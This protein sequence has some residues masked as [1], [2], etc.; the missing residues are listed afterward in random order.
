MSHMIRED[1]QEAILDIMNKT[2]ESDKVSPDSH[3]FKE[4]DFAET[5][6]VSRSTIREAISSLEIRGYLKRVHGRGIKAIDSSIEAVSNSLNDLFI[7]SGVDYDDVLQFRN[8]IEI[9][10]AGIAA[11]NHKK[12]HL[13][14]MKQYIEVMNDHVSYK[15]Y[16]DADIKFHQ[17]VIRASGNQMLQALSGAYDT[18]LRSVIEM[19]TDEDFRPEGEMKFHAKILTAIESGDAKASEACMEDHLRASI[20]NVDILKK[21]CMN[22]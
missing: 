22:W 4:G 9:K 3:Y 16:L 1:I 18:I 7:R 13:D 11:K 6:G 20:H 12:T 21:R 2:F 19:S 15:S 5:L 10:G 17:E 8:I 14:N